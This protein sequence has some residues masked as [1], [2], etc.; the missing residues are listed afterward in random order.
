MALGIQF[1]D[2]F[3]GDQFCSLYYSV[4]NLYGEFRYA[5][6][7]GQQ[8]IFN[9]T[10]LSLSQLWAAHA[11]I[12]LAGMWPRLAMPI[13]RGSRQCLRHYLSCFD[14]DTPFA[15]TIMIQ[16][17]GEA[18]RLPDLCLA[19]FALLHAC[20]IHLLNVAKYALSIVYQFVYYNWR[21]KGGY[22]SASDV[23]LK[24]ADEL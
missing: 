14:S 9:T 15:D 22:Y 6:C 19:D 3:L 23:H 20:R 8:L 16:K 12:T 21:I 13:R 5:V 11:S 4:Y 24:R 1:R 17:Q 2:F 7:V 18:L 10:A